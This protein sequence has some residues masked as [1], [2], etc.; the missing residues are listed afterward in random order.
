VGDHIS[1]LTACPCRR[2]GGVGSDIAISCKIACIQDSDMPGKF[3][4]DIRVYY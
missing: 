2:I 1:P 4:L 3:S